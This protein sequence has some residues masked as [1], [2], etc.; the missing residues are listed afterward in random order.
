MTPSVASGTSA[1]SIAPAGRPVRR[2]LIIEDDTA[3]VK[4]Y[5]LRLEKAITGPYACNVARGLAEALRIVHEESPDVALLDLNVLDSDGWHTF[6]ELH[7]SCPELPIVVVTGRQDREFALNAVRLGAQDFILKDEHMFDVLDRVVA[8]AIERGRNR[9]E[10]TLAL[11]RVMEREKALEA[12]VLQLQGMQASLAEAERQKTTARLVLGLAHELKNPL[13]ILR[14]GLDHLGRKVVAPQERSVVAE[15]TGA[16]ERADK[17]IVDL[18][19]YGAPRPLDLK[20]CP[21]PTIIR[22][23]TGLLATMAANHHVDLLLDL[24]GDELTMD[25]DPGMIEQAIL[26]LVMNAIQATPPGGTVTIRTEVKPL[27]TF[28]GAEDD[29]RHGRILSIEIL[30]TGKG[31]APE[32]LPFL[33]D[34]FYTADKGATGVGLGLSVS[35]MII[36]LHGGSLTIENRIEGGACACIRFII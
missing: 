32:H 5:R 22:S 11:K 34:P 8:H 29:G 36:Q 25:V 35:R 33:F 19:H 28:F 6:E 24:A 16:V 23:A 20:S 17:L 13:Q 31:I 18:L 21:L 26:N 30:D 3:F 14:M 2:V 4:L 27:E 9:A 12:S 1:D 15:L 10:L 7:R